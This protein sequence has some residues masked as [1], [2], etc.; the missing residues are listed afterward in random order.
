MI[1]IEKGKEPD[2]LT[3][4]RKKPYATYENCNKEDIRDALLA[5]QGHL[6]AYCMRR[7]RKD[8]MKI[9]H[10]FPEAELDEPGR[11]EYSNMLGCCEGHVEGGR[12]NDDT[13]DTHK[14]SDHITL[15]PT[16]RV[17]IDQIKYKQLSGEIYSEDEA[18]NKDLNETLN[19][20]CSKQFLKENRRAA[21]NAVKNKICRMSQG[22]VSRRQ[23]EKL[24]MQYRK[25]DENGMKEEY[26]GIVIWYLKKKLA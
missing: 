23:L 12:H 5:E 17:H 2:S 22:T 25:A 10:W 24:L 1:Y 26:A 3:Q 20:N 11:L 21:L 19:L 8:R 18:F 4:H 6:C 13:C 7:I 16:N 14:R 9:E 15:I